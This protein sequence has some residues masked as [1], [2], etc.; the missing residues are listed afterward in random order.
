VVGVSWPAAIRNLV[1]CLPAGIARWVLVCDRGYQLALR[2]SLTDVLP[3]AE[4][5]VL[6][7]DTPRR[8]RSIAER[9]CDDPEVGLL[10]FLCFDGERLRWGRNY[11]NATLPFAAWPPERVRLCFDVTDENFRELFSEA[12]R[13]VRTRGR[14]LHRRLLREE[15]LTLTAG[16]SRATLRCRTD[17]WELHSGLE[18]D[19]YVLPSGEIECVP[20][21]VDGSVEVN[22]WIVGTILFGMKY[23]RIG[24][25]QLKLKFR[26][27]E[28]VG[29]TGKQRSLCNELETAFTLLPG[30]RRVAELGVGQSKAVTR[31]ANKE[32]VGC[33]WHERHFGVHLGLGA[34]LHEPPGR[35]TQH[36]LDLVLATGS[37]AGNAGQA[38][39]SW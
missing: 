29:I 37:L 2:R 11:R 7:S 35:V 8:V 19:D 14:M 38:I 28:V 26:R 15:R 39:V 30:L 4:S 21:S 13:R 23:G 18:P 5:I 33:L 31:A 25:G 9:Y 20:E 1:D 24:P 27:G 17:G 12:P 32:Q 34:G 16:T 36:H 6:G 22:G 10:E 3:I